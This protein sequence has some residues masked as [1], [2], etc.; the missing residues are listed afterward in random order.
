M[1]KYSE[2][3]NIRRD[4]LK[5]LV[6]KGVVPYP[7]R[8]A[9][10]ATLAEAESNFSE[11]KKKPQ[12]LVGRI[13]AIREHG[14]SAF[15][16][17]EDGTGT[18]Q[19]YVKRDVLGDEQF[20]LW[21]DGVDIG[22]IIGCTGKLFATKRGEKTLEVDTF[23]FL[24]K[25]LTPLPEKWHGL[26]DVEA[27]Y[28]KRYVDLLAN[29]GVRKIFRTRAKLMR[30]IREFLDGEGFLEVE[31]P[32]LHPIPGG[33]V[34]RPFVTHSNA[35]DADFY[36]RIA[37]ELYLKRLIVGGFERVY[38]IARCFRNEGIDQTHSPEFT[39][40]EFYMAYA[41]YEQL[42]DFTEQLIRT[43]LKE[44]TGGTA[45][46]FRKKSI[47]FGKQFARKN[48]SDLLREHA[49]ITVEE[50]RKEKNRKKLISKFGLEVPEGA[51]VGKIADEILKDFVLPKLVQPT[52]LTDH[53]IELSPL[54]KRK[55]GDALTA[56][57]FQLIAGGMELVNAFTELNDPIDQ[58][59]RFVAQVEARRRG[60]AEAHGY[61]ADFLGALEVGMPPT[62]GFGLG[63]DRLML[64]VTD[65]QNLK[66]VI[67]F[68]TLKPEK[69][70]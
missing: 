32:I 21:Q 12:V 20:S 58:E 4:K 47:D 40:V 11:L 26:A 14:G 67:L 6:A 24:A 13:R 52:F 39:Q 50:I 35:L 38:E 61:D 25:A 66:E 16:T 60:D 33:A 41:D 28:R 63:I 36:L 37:P 3:E 29:P 42:M 2:Q 53:P 7:A 43:I 10:S 70:T 8:V 17:L 59:E 48:F 44:A 23:R 54:A 49:G 18:F 68:P 65:A 15:A 5:R 34:A 9:R 31:T 51:G 1:R 55:E 69:A 62:A 64:L 22:D 30:A 46:T 56:E 45:L 19:I 27:R 57:R